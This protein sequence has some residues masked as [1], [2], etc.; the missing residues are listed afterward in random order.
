LRGYVADQL[1]NRANPL[2]R[3]C[4]ALHRPKGH[5][6][7]IGG[8]LT[9]MQVT[10]TGPSSSARS[11]TPIGTNLSGHCAAMALLGGGTAAQDGTGDAA[12]TNAAIGGA[13]IGDG[14]ARRQR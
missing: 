3:T 2:G 5:P 10:R 8:L 1:N 13:E 14:A 4:K 7:A 12:A 11:N 6:C 9:R